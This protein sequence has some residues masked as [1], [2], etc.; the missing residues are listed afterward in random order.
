MA[1]TQQP[2]SEKVVSYLALGQIYLS[3]KATEKAKEEFFQALKISQTLNNTYFQYLSYYKI[4]CFYSSLNVPPSIPIKYFYNSKKMFNGNIGDKTYYLLLRFI[5]FIEID[6]DN[7]DL[8]I[9]TYSELAKIISLRGE[10]NPEHSSIYNNL[11]VIYTETKDFAKAELYLK[12]SLAL[13]V[14]DSIAYAR[15][16]MNYGPLFLEKKEYIKA[17]QYYNYAYRIQIKYNG[18]E[19]GTECLVYIGMTNERTDNYTVAIKKLELANLHSKEYKQPGLRRRLLPHLANCYSKTNEYKKASYVA[20]KEF[21][22]VDQQMKADYEREAIIKHNIEFSFEKQLLEDS[23]KH[24]Q[25][26]LQIQFENE[27][28]LS[29]KDEK[30]KRNIILYFF[31]PT[32]GFFY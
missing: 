11:G 8:A 32:R 4:G 15:G 21:N 16:L 14:N 29:I 12:K 28:K 6:S 18:D 9:K 5:G 7:K 30:Q 17:L 31:V 20:L 3:R 13:I 23:I 1:I 2:D 22:E 26:L 25:S 24:S 27:K 19:G 10:D